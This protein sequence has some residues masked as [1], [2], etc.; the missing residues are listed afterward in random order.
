LWWIFGCL[1]KFHESSWKWRTLMKLLQT[2]KN[3][4]WN[5]RTSEPSLDFLLSRRSK[6]EGIPANPE[7]KS[8]D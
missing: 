8:D 1:K 7:I 5:W 6:F 4:K 2:S 3:S